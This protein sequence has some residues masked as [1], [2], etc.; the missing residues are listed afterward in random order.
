MIR[1]GT[2]GFEL[3]TLYEFVLECYEM[4][5]SFEFM[6]RLDDCSRSYEVADLF[7]ESGHGKKYF[8]E[9]SRILGNQE[10]I[11]SKIIVYKSQF[12]SDTKVSRF[13]MFDLSKRDLNLLKMKNPKVYQYLIRRNYIPDLVG[14]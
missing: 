6:D 9:L 7:N 11:I 8:T 12:F 14:E 1:C 4:D 3:I 13:F 5:F 10:F 2:N